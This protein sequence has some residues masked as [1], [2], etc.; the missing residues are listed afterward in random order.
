MLF[1]VW[2]QAVLGQ[3]LL[4]ARGGVR[5]R[6]A[7]DAL[8]PDCV[9]VLAEVCVHPG[10]EGSA[11]PWF[12]GASRVTEGAWGLVGCGGLRGALWIQVRKR[13]L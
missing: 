6:G 11:S 4:T 1:G 3:H 7:V 8:M 5:V 12:R 13:T 2:K 9:C 10:P